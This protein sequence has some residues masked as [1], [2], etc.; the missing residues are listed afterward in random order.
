MQ[1]KLAP[2]R[3]DMPVPYATPPAAARAIPTLP[4]GSL[5]AGEKEY[6]LLETAQIQV[7]CGLTDAQWDTDL[8]ELYTRMLMEEGH[9]TAR[10]RV[11]LEDTF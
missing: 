9:T 2:Y 10:V 7:A 5:S 6:S 8:P 1:S 4:A 11:L 3:K